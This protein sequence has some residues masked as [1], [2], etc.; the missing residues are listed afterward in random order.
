MKWFAVHNRA[1]KVHF[2]LSS[3]L[4]FLLHTRSCQYQIKILKNIINFFT[5]LNIDAA[6]HIDSTFLEPKTSRNF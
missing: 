1:R 3:S 6:I 5:F 2:R 4:G